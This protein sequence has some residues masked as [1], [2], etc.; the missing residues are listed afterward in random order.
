MQRSAA[1]NQSRSRGAEQQNSTAQ[2]EREQNGATKEILSSES[3]SWLACDDSLTVLP[4][5]ALSLALLQIL[6]LCPLSA[7]LA[8]ASSGAFER[9]DHEKKYDRQMRSQ[10]TTRRIGEQSRADR[11]KGS[12]SEL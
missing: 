8:M 5:L 1:E 4:S 9:T 6:S 11:G 2:R 10:H 7:L 12:R 3:G